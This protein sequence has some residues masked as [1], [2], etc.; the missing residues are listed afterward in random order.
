MYKHIPKEKKKVMNPRL[1]KIRE[2]ID[3]NKVLVRLCLGRPWKGKARING[4]KFVPQA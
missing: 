2:N 3:Q 4:R 1:D